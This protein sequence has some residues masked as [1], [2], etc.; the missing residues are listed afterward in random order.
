MRGA[1][2]L[3]VLLVAGAA[4]AQDACEALR[5]APDA[6]L[7]AVTPEGCAGVFTAGQGCAAY[8]ATVGMVCVARFGGQP[9]CQREP[10]NPQRCADDT[11]HASDWCTCAPPAPPDPP[12]PPDPPAPIDPDVRVLARQGDRLTWCGAPIRLV[13]YGHYGVVAERAFD[14]VA[15]FDRLAGEYGLNF[16]RVW[17]QYHWANDLMPFPGGRGDYDLLA[18]DLDFFRRLRAVALDAARR[19]I[20]VQVTLFD[21]VQLEGPS[22]SGNRWIDSPYRRANNRQAYLDDPT[23]F[24]ALGDAPVWVEVNRPYV[25]RVV[26][27][28]CDLPNVIYEVMNEPMGSGADAGRGSPAFVDAVI[29]ELDRLLA[30]PVCVGSKVVSTNDNPL[31]T[32]ANPRVDLVAVHV[33][34]ERAGDYAAVGKPILVSN[35]GDLSQVSDAHGFGE[36]TQGARAARVRAYAAG[37][38]AADV[39]GRAHL[40]VLDKDLHGASWL[41]RDYQPRAENVTPA[42]LGAAAEAVV[43]RATP[44]PGLLPVEPDAGSPDAG[45]PPDAGAPDAGR[46]DAGPADAA[47]AVVDAGAPDRGVARADAAPV[48]AADAATRARDAVATAQ[49]E[50][51]P[52]GCAQQGRGGAPPWGVI[53]LLG[54]GAVRR[55]Y[56]CAR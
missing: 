45:S 5:V 34:P 38:F 25:E 51:D 47:G 10:E 33:P 19:G 41:S 29:A 18:A 13:G 43:T 15:F 16:V 55:R 6:E 30:R 11:G 28:L 35:D 1:I 23:A 36:L 42:L 14:H 40:E 8:C 7:C 49:D 54:L 37:A 50:T 3:A 21:S 24:D 2:I 46:R 4:R 27:T 32:V 17:G 9:G 53:G 48:A 26:D 52:F 22:D 44:C 39:V 20:V 56:R 12:D 31:R